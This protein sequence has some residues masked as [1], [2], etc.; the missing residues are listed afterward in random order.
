MARRHTRLFIA[1][2]AR[3]TINLDTDLSTM[4]LNGSTSLAPFNAVEYQPSMSTPA[5]APPAVSTPAPAVTGFSTSTSLRLNARYT[6]SYQ[7]A[8]SAP[9]SPCRVVPA[10]QL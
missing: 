1:T 9:A 6:V 7:S 4:Q 8:I 5:S 10:P 3:T 2:I